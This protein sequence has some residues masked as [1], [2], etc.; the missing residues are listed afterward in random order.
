MPLSQTVQNIFAPAK[1]NLYLHVT[2][3]RD[4]NYHNL[5]SLV[6]FTDIGDSITIE[7]AEKFDFSIQGPFAANFPQD[8][9]KATDKSTNLIVKAVFMMAQIL[10][11]LPNFKITLNKNL[12]IASGMG[13]GSSNA[14]ATLWALEKRWGITELSTILPDIFTQLGA[15]VP[16]CYYAHP[17][18]IRAIGDIVDPVPPLPEAD[19]VLINPNQSCPTPSVFDRHQAIDQSEITL[20]DHFG[21]LDNFVHF[22]QKQRN[23]LTE[24]AIEIV[25]EI[26]QILESLN[27]QPGCQLSRMS[28]SG[29]TCFGIFINADLAQNARKAISAAYP[30]WWVQHGKINQ[31]ERY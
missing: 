30:K 15:D 27:N 2:G 24:S 7:P 8:A 6:C 26:A 1:I 11:Q 31:I 16:V 4:D 5:D 22:L 3:R 19:I 21:D 12:P 17:A 18:R 23:D 14:A 20:P 28:G 9:Q 29:A 13:G 10:E 25:P